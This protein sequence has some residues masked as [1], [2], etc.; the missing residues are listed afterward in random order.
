MTN[1]PQKEKNFF[2]KKMGSRKKRKQ[3]KNTP[4]LNDQTFQFTF[5]K[6]EERRKKITTLNFV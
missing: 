1:S 4:K 2:L 3:K 5:L 6:C